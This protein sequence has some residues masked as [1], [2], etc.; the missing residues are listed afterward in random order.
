M[1]DSGTVIAAFLATEL[2]T[3]YGYG[4]NVFNGPVRPFGA[5]M[6]AEAIFC[7]ETG[8]DVSFPNRESVPDIE[9]GSPT[10]L[11]APTV[12]IRV[13]S[14]P[15]AYGSGKALANLVRSSLHLVIPTGFV[16]SQIRESVPTYLGA[17]KNGCHEW[18]MNLELLIDDER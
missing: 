17:D 5:G 8:G 14:E 12:Q 10:Q 3:G 7:L 13:R 2:G 18:S 4:T 1:F 11:M 6:P 15:G 9:D 16:E